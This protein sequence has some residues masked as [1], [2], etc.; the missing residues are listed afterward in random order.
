MI[1]HFLIL[2]AADKSR[3]VR[4]LLLAG[5]TIRMFICIFSVLST[6]L[7]A[8]CLKLVNFDTIRP[9]LLQPKHTTPHL[10]RP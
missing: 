3:R 1:H 7:S 5:G 4:A 9:S 10:A 8:L 2:Q 6:I